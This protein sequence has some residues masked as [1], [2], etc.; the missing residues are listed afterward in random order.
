MR[1][2]S[3]IA[4]AAALAITALPAGAQNVTIPAWAQY[5]QSLPPYHPDRQV[6]GTV[7]SWGHGFLRDMMH[8]WEHDFHR[9]QPNVTFRDDLASSA[10]AMAGLYTGRANLGV[11]AREIVPMEV[12]AYQK[13]TGQKVFP[14]TVLTGSYADPD[15]LMAL[16]VFVNRDNPLAQLDFRQLDAIFGAQHL[17][18][19]P[20][21]I[22]TWGQ[23]GLGGAWKQRPIH[24]YA[25]PAGDEAPPYFFSQTVMRGSMLWNGRLQELDETTLPDGRHIDGYQRAVDAVAE[26]RDGVAISVAGYRNP[27]AKLVAIAVAAGGPYVPPTTASVADRS[28][29]LSRSVT[30][31]INDGPKIPPDPAVVEFLRYVLSRDGQEQAL[32]EGDFL[33]LTPSIARAQLAKLADPAT[34]RDADGAPAITDDEPPVLELIRKIPVPQMTGTWDHLTVDPKTERLFLSAQDQQMVYVVPLTGS[35]G[36]RRITQGF[37]RPQGELYVPGADRLVVTSGRGARVSLFDGHELR[38]A[39]ALALSAG[40][41]MIA[42]DPAH[43]VLYVESGGTDSHRGPGWLA[44]IDPR[45]GRLTGRV[46]TGYRAAALVMAQDSRRLYVAIPALDQVAVIDTDTKRIV[47]RWQVPGRP[48]SMALD[49]ASGRLFVATRTFAG[50][51]RPPVLSVLDTKD[52]RL[53]VTL[54]GKDATENMYWDAAHRLIYT[55]SLDGYVQAYHERDADH[56]DLVATVRTV[57]HAGTSQFVPGLGELCVAAPP[58]DGRPA[59]VWIFRPVGAFGR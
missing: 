3:I 33:P 22:R 27:H 17:A 57:Q 34:H 59:A 12:A 31:Y 32:R 42:L 8:D 49:E 11:L 30:F 48:A 25:G 23:L 51:P 36:I 24:P 52:G 7:T 46:T 41:D 1:I 26:D 20:S 35:A 5:V 16:G 43:G 19:E 15:K 2:H 39:A 28:Y 50:D 13:M 9:F 6:S 58:H 53:L 14:V 44:V 55:S 4:A 10:A 47:S 38:P 54:P 37:D 56:Y 21:N 45:S 29:P 40:A 18:G